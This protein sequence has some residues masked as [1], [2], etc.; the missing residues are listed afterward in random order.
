MSSD[1]E[2]V[3]SIRYPLLFRYK[4]YVAGSGFL[5]CVGDFRPGTDDPKKQE[6]TMNGGCTECA[7]PQ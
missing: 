7:H 6:R 1:K 3:A 2:Q 5:A 4:D